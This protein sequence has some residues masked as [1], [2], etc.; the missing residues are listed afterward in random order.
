MNLDKFEGHTPGPWILYH[1][2]VGEPSIHPLPV[3]KLNE[4]DWN[5]I[6]AAPLLLAEIKRL[7][8]LITKEEEE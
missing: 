7:K 3:G 8:R 4:I 2:A 6:V 5:L 1:R